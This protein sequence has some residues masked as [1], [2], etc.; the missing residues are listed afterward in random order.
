MTLILGP[1]LVA[2]ESWDG[3]EATVTES[4]EAITEADA[5]TWD[6]SSATVTESSSPIVDSQPAAGRSSVQEQGPIPVQG[7]SCGDFTFR[8]PE[9][10][11]GAQKVREV[12]QDS[13]GVY[14]Y[15]NVH[16][17]PGQCNAPSSQPSQPSQPR[18]VN[19][20]V[21]QKSWDNLVTELQMAGYNGSWDEGSAVAAFNR[22]ACPASQPPAPPAP[23]LPAPPPPP[24]APVIITAN[25]NTSSNVNTNTNTNTNTV[26]NTVT[27]QAPQGGVTR[28]VVREVAVVS[29]GNVG[30]GTSA[31]VLG[32]KELPKTGLPL[33]AWAALAF[34][35]AGVKIKRFSKVKQ[36]LIDNPSY[37]WEDRQYRK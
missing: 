5:P 28:E 35:P 31:A 34:I 9:C 36:E 1:S 11:W 12:W 30:I 2:A 6:G 24:P 17:E 26:T 19:T 8:Y 21:G 18:T 7:P 13:C 23:P 10:D 22:A 29:T 25:N 33:L 27:V 16:S 32:V 20:C 15:R 14:Q 37:I 3:S 4:S